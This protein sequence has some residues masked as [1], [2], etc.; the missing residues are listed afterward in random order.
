[1]SDE[2][3]WGEPPP[4]SGNSGWNQLLADALRAR[5]GEWAIWK[6]SAASANASNVKSGALAAFRPARAFETRTKRNE[7]GSE[8]LHTIWVRYIGENG[9]YR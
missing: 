2:I 1:M 8:R 5:P 9:E 4:R 3:E 6:R 7:R